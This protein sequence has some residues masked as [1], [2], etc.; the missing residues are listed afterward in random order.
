MLQSLCDVMLSLCELGEGQNIEIQ[1]A[2]ELPDPQSLTTILASFME[3]IGN[4]DH[5]YTSI[6]QSLR[7]LVMLA[8]YD[9]TFSYMKTYVQ[10]QFPLCVWMKSM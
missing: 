1:L 2:N 7:T 4:Y 6:L 3:H 8:Y 10:T 5:C 9:Y